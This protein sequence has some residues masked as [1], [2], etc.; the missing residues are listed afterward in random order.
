MLITRKTRLFIYKNAICILTQSLWQ[1]SAIVGNAQ[2]YKTMLS[3]TRSNT[4]AEAYTTQP[5]QH[6]LHSSAMLS[7]IRIPSLSFQGEVSCQK[8]LCTEL[9]V[10]SMYRKE[11]S[12]EKECGKCKGY[13]LTAYYDL[14]LR[15]AQQ[16]QAGFTEKIFLERAGIDLGFPRLL[17][18]RSSTELSKLDT[19]KRDILLK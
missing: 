19:S 9:S 14:K 18:R 6:C 12:K 3:G 5:A 4:S 10:S 16:N 1:C 13:W 15:I 2:K 11:S 17:A 8:A 7:K